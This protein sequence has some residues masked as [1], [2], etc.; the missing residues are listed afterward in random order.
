VIGADVWIGGGA[1]I[2][3]GVS[4]GDGAIVGAGAVVT[5]DVP[6]GVTIVGNPA[7]VR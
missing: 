4:I 7:K 3:P 2:L 5:R 6:A 1:I